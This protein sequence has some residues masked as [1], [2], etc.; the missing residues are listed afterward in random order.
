MAEVTYATPES[1]IGTD[2]GGEESITKPE[3]RSITLGQ[4][5]NIQQIAET[6]LKA[7]TLAITKS[8]SVPVVV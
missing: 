7:S 2:W 1:L 5:E 4:N 6:A 3:W 8:K